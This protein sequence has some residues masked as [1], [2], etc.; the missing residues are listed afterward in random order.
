MRS[1]CGFM[2]ASALRPRGQSGR[3]LCN[4]IS[5]LV[6]AHL[7]R[8]RTGSWL[9]LCHAAPQPR[10]WRTRCHTYPP[11]NAS[12]AYPNAAG[13]GARFY[14]AQ[15]RTR[16]VS[17]DVLYEFEADMY[18]TYSRAAPRK[19]MEFSN[20]SHSISQPPP[21]HPHPML[22]IHIAFAFCLPPPDFVCL[23]LG[24]CELI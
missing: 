16:E 15:A 8:D 12:R 24:R 11:R 3:W 14:A 17:A 2:I 4:V 10:L 9:A 7:L 5:V 6:S 13:R 23:S 20:L 21:P 18:L 22:L 1:P 19:S